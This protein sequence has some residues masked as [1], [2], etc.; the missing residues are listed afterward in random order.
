MSAV[1]DCFEPSPQAEHVATITVEIALA[2]RRN[3]QSMP[4]FRPNPIPLDD[5]AR[6]QRFLYEHAGESVRIAP[7]QYV[8]ANGI[9]LPAGTRVDAFGATLTIS[10]TETG[11][12]LNSHSAWRGGTI[13]SFQREPRAQ[14]HSCFQAGHYWDGFYIND[15]S[16]EDVDLEAVGVNSSGIAIYSGS[17]NGTVTGVTHGDSNS[18]ENVIQLHWGCDGDPTLGTFHPHNI[19]IRNVK[20]GKLTNSPER[21][22]TEACPIFL[23]GCYNVTVDNV[24][25]EEC[26]TAITYLTGDFGF[27]HSGLKGPLGG[28]SIRGVTSQLCS[29]HGVI[30]TNYCIGH[31]TISAGCVR[32]SDCSL[33]GHGNGNGVDG[34][35]LDRCENALFDHNVI[36]GFPVGIAVSEPV[37]NV[38]F[39][40]T[41]FQHLINGIGGPFPGVEILP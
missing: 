2:A 16:V 24:D 41:I 29:T 31:E 40:S 4:T 36:S 11:V 15:F 37:V 7:G 27:L 9:I 38:K 39:K 19:G 18:L 1:S 21:P 26:R 12:D 10:T 35:Y 13:R 6:L 30:I 23:S 34:I 8:L 5:G 28:V 20:V 3:S 17:N 32:I 25:I 14:A 22:N 33:F